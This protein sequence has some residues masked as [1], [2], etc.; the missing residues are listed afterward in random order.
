MGPRTAGACSILNRQTAERIVTEQVALGRQQ[1]HVT[2][3]EVAK[4]VM[5]AIQ[6]L[7]GRSLAGERMEDWLYRWEYA[8]AD[9]DHDLGAIDF[10]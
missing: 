4:A 8:A 9:P 1:G 3:P 10:T 7:T 5:Q 2:V 6:G